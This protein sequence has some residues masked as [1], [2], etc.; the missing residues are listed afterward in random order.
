MS[1]NVGLLRYKE[2]IHVNVNFK[3]NI[4]QL[5]R[6]RILNPVTILCIQQLPYLNTYLDKQM[7][8]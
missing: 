1:Q 4:D 7:P 5:E 8:G 6:A 2:C 3:R